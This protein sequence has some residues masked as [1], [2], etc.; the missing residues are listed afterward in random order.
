VKPKDESH[1]RHEFDS[2][3]K[4]VLK[5]NARNY[6]E[7]Q[8]ERGEREASIAELSEQELSSLSYCDEYAI[9]ETVFDVQGESVSVRDGDLAQ[10]IAALPKEKRDIVLLSYFV[11]MSDCEIAECMEL[12]RRTVTYRR[13]SSLRELKKRLE[14]IGYE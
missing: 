13:A 2:F 14:E 5:Y 11:G 9:E 12:V 6:Y 8:K 4:K 3:C 7:K 10:A 1:V